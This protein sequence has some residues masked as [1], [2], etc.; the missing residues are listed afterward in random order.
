MMKLACKDLNPETECNYEVTAETKEDTARIMMSHAKIVHD[1]DIEGM[2]D[3]EI[4]EMME[5]VVHK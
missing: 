5:V 1:K 4:M 2:S 3:E